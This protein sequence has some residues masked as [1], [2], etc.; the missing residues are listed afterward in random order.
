MGKNLFIFCVLK[1]IFKKLMI[2]KCVIF[3]FHLGFISF[4]II[5]GLF[6]FCGRYV[7]LIIQN[8]LFKNKTIQCT[9]L[10]CFGDFFLLVNLCIIIF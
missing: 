10:I 2:F 9:S 3:A 7:G 6:C 8:F 4:F 5:N 1:F